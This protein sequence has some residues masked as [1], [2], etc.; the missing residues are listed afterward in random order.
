MLVTVAFFVMVYA[1]V[2]REYRVII[3]L[4]LTINMYIIICSYHCIYV[5]FC[6]VYT[7]TPTG[8]K[9]RLDSICG[10]HFHES[11][12]RSVY[13]LLFVFEFKFEYESHFRYFIYCINISIMYIRNTD[14]CGRVLYFYCAHKNIY[15]KRTFTYFYT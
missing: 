5:H 2:P 14:D 12:T 8:N 1:R 10:E 15:N 3:S 6:I 9:H 4:L 11:G 7:Y 13:K